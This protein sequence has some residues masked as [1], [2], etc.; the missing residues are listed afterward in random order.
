MSIPEYATIAFSIIPTPLK[1]DVR[2]AQFADEKDVKSDFEITDVEHNE[3]IVEIR[4]T[5]SMVYNPPNIIDSCSVFFDVK[6]D[7]VEPKQYFRELKTKGA[8]LIISD[9]FR[10][11]QEECDKL[12]SFM[13]RENYEW[14]VSAQPQ[15]VEEYTDISISSIMAF[16]KRT[17]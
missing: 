1:I 2:D 15:T 16:L 17:S 4:F 10:K 12:F 6:A 14:S 5:L 13:V 7:I 3:S 8:M 9:L 11:T